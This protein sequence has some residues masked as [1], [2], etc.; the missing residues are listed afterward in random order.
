MTYI[1]SYFVHTEKNSQE[2]RISFKRY[3]WCSRKLHL[4]EESAPALK[5]VQERCHS[6]QNEWLFRI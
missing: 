3:Y 4:H 6:L 5:V 1:Y 2:Y